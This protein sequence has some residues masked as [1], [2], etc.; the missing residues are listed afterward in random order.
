METTTDSK[1]ARGSEKYKDVATGDVDREIANFP[2]NI[3]GWGID[4]D[5]DN[6]PTY[7]MKRYTG[8]DYERIHYLRPPQQPVTMEILQSIERPGL[9]AVFGTS[10]PP[11]GL[12]GS[13]RRFAYKFSEAD[14]RHWLSLVLADRVNA[15]EGIVDDLKQGIVPNIFVER[16]WTAEWKYNRTGLI[17]KVA[18][19]A[20]VTAAV[21]TL[22]VLKNRSKRETAFS[23]VE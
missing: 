11:T 10:S 17:K 2:K 18:V 3:P 4:A 8:A 15:M 19:G 7:P 23:E 20:A 1:Y 12:S 5:P 13:I 22:I 16:G 21:V 9:T 14:A 6:N